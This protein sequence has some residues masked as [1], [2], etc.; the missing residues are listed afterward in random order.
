MKC[1]SV[2]LLWSSAV[3]AQVPD[4]IAVAPSRTVNLV[5]DQAV[6]SANV[7]AASD[8]SQDQVL[9]VFRNAGAANPVIVYSNGTSNYAVSFTTPAEAMRPMAQKLDQIRLKRPPAFVDFSYNAT[10]G[11]SDSAVQAARANLLPQLIRDARERAQALAAAAS[12]KLGQIQSVTD[13]NV[14]PIPT[15]ARV[16]DFTAGLALSASG[17]QSTFTIAVGFNL[18]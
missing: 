15:A 2:I 4:G 16:G 8:A 5:P 14:V 12:V 3:L 6:F 17:T 10:L 13:L 1:S 9:E 18:Q 11:A 7:A